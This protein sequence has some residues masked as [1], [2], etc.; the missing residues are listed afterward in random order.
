MSKRKIEVIL[1][2]LHHL[3][4]QLIDLS[5]DRIRE[6]LVKLGNPQD[7]LPT[8]IH[9][10]GTN[11]KG[12]TIAFLKAI[13]EEAGK[14]VH[15]Y[16]SPHLV[17]FNERIQ[18][19]DGQGRSRPVSE[20]V[21][22]R[23][24]EAVERI[25]DGA[26]MTFFEIT[27]AAALQLFSEIPADVVLLEVGLGG[28]FDATNVIR[29]PRL[30]VITPVSLD[31]MD[32]LGETVALIAREKAGILK[33]GVPAVVAHQE[34]AAFDVIEAHAEAVG[35]LLIAA[36]RD[37]D[38]YEQ[39]G[40]MV[41]QG[42][43]LLLDLPLPS[44]IGRHQIANAGLAVAAILSIPEL[45][46]DADAIEAGL[47]S[48]VWPARMQRLKSPAIH[49]AAG[50]NS[51]VWLDG[52]HNPAG[53]LAVGRV[54]ADLDERSPKP[55]YLIVGMLA[56]KDARGFLAPFA[57]L[58][59]RALMVP[60]SG[61]GSAQRPNELV[62]IATDL[63]MNAGTSRDVLSALAEIRGDSDGPK[64]IL[65]CGSLYLAGA[66]LAIEESAPNVDRQA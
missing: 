12:S 33:Q 9:V 45:G 42:P 37:F 51:E 3:H 55:I 40:R 14:R 62:Q 11:G 27:T 22:V 50:P 34:A 17:S 28:R 48:A 65:I 49:T 5:L 56:N 7:R 52:G 43:D 53:G 60:F 21:L 57:G 64:R 19:P 54:L 29:S 20:D 15:V 13:L 44:L 18:V 31:H 35:A 6:L 24:L 39:A 10:A 63:G 1:E 2:R 38:A 36:G 32:K 61:D 30:S 26:P 16:T 8:V 66:V 25:N 47:Q 4:P 59:R 41:F 23:V 46:V 58:A